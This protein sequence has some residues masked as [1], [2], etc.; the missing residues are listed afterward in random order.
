MRR[1]WIVVHNPH[2]KTDPHGWHIFLKNL[3]VDKP[4]SCDCVL[5]YETSMPFKGRSDRGRKGIVRVASVDGEAVDM[6]NF[7]GYPHK[8]N[9]VTTRECFIPLKEV[10]KIVRGLFYR[11][12]L[13]PIDKLQYMRLLELISN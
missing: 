7:P 9:C 2:L 5:F 3:V 12:N 1:Y 4:A 13:T 11:R 10:R 6:P 8:I